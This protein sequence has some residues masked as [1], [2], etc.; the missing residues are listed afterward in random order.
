MKSQKLFTV[1]LAIL[2]IFGS[3]VLGQEVQ[4]AYDSTDTPQALLERGT[5]A[6]TLVIADSGICTRLS[7]QVNISHDVIDELEAYLIGPDGTRV[8]LFAGVGAGGSDMSDTW[9]VD[10]AAV[11]IKEG[12]APFTDGYRAEGNLSDFDFKNIEG[13]WTLEIK[14]SRDGI[15]GTL[16]SWALVFRAIT[17]NLYLEDM[18][19]STQIDEWNWVDVDNATVDDGGLNNPSGLYSLRLNGNPSGGDSITSRTMNLSGCLGATFTYS[20]ER[21]APNPG[22]DSPEEGEDLIFEYNTGAGWGELDRQLGEGFPMRSYEQVSVVLPPEALSGYCSF[23]IRSIGTAGPYDDWFVDDV[24][25]VLNN[26]ERPGIVSNPGFEGQI[27]GWTAAQTFSSSLWQS[28]GSY[29]ARVFTMPQM[30]HEAGTWVGLSQSI[31]LS[32]IA[33]IKFDASTVASSGGTWEN[34][35]AS[36]YIDDTEVWSDKGADKTWLDVPIDTA[37]YTGIHTLSLRLSFLET[38]NFDEDVHFDNI[39]TYLDE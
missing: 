7:V 39:R 20:Y 1:V 18:F 12:E 5:T 14:D 31:D 35:V 21:F 37:D 15:S 23:R 26:P 19:S 30:K 2:A 24:K 4:N 32:N 9:F 29:S 17:S 13:A 25:L 16:N 3:I 22:K 38:G 6:S 8:K 33:A 34:C 28:D 36:V 10:N 11:S 27:W